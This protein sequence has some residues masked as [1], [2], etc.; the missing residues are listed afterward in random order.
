MNISRSFYNRIDNKN[1]FFESNHSIVLD[2]REVKSPLAVLNRYKNILKANG[3]ELVLL[4][5]DRGA[6]EVYSYLI[7][8]SLIN[9][10]VISVAE[11]D[12]TK[13]YVKLIKYASKDLFLFANPNYSYSYRQMTVVLDEFYSGSGSIIL[14]YE[15]T[16]TSVVQV[17]LGKSV[18]ADS[19]DLNNSLFDYQSLIYFKSRGYSIMSQN[20]HFSVIAVKDEM[21]AGVKNFPPPPHLKEGVVWDWENNNPA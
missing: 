7:K 1:L 13:I 4:V 10:K 18:I 15:E 12:W 2:V 11:G 3:L 14:R 9:T 8:H 6:T 5:S 17:L 21:V 20:S 19:L 16:G